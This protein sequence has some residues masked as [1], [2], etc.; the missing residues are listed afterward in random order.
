MSLGWCGGRAQVAA[1]LAALDDDDWSVRQAAWVAL[2]NLT[3]MEWPFD[4]LASRELQAR[5]A[6]K[7]RDWWAATPTDRPPPEALKLLKEIHPRPHN[8]AQGAKVTASSVYKGPLEALTDGALQGAFWQTKKVPF[9]QWVVVDLGAVRSIGSVVVHQYGPGFCLTDYELQVSVDGK[10]FEQVLRKKGRTLPRLNLRFDARP[11]RFVRLVSYA[12]ENKTYPTTLRE[13]EAYAETPA[14]NVASETVDHRLERGLRAMGALGGSGSVEAALR[15]LEPH[16]DREPDSPAESTMVQAGLRSL[17]R[18]GD[19]RALEALVEFLDQPYWARFA[20]DAL[21]DLGDERAAPALLAAYPHYARDLDDKQPARIPADDRPGF[22]AADRMYETPFEIAS[23]LARLPLERPEILAALRRIGP[24]LAVNIPSNYDGAMIYEPEAFQAITAHLLGSAGLRRASCEAAFAALGLPVEPTGVSE[25]DVLLKLAQRRHGEIPHAAAWLPT[26]CEARDVKPLIALLR[27]ENGWVRINAAKALMFLGAE[28]AVEP[29]MSILA[30]SKTEAEY[31]WFGGFVFGTPLQGH[32]EYNA[33]PPRWR[34][35]FVRALGRLRATAS[36]PLLEKTLNDDRNA[37]EVR[38]AAAMALDEIGGP[39]ALTELRRAE[40]GHPFHSVRL[41]AREALWRRGLLMDGDP[42]DE[43]ST[44][45]PISPAVARPATAA[46]DLRTGSSAPD[47]IVFIKGPNRMP[48]RFQI[49]PWRQTYS[50][51]DS[52][53]TY[54][55][56]WNLYRLEPPEPQGRLTQLTRFEDGYVADCEVSWDGRRIVFA[57]RGGE[58]DPWWHIWEIN[59]D[60][61]GLRQLTRGPYHDV[62]PVQLGD[63]RI[64]FSSSRIG[65]RDEYHGYHATGLTVMNADGGDIHCIGFNLGRDDEPAVLPDGRIV[66]SRLELFYS[67]LKTERTLHAVFPDGTQDVTLYGP[68]RRGFWREITRKSGEK[69]WGEAPPRHRVLRLTQPQPFE[70]NRVLCATTGGLTL[71]GPGSLQEELVPH[72]QSLAATSPFPLGNGEILCAA[73]TKK[74]SD[75]EGNLALYRLDAASG[76]MRLVYRDPEAA[77]F[78]ARPLVARRPP[79]VLPESAAS[80][81]HGYTAELFCASVNNSRID[82]VARRAKL[83]RVIEGMPAVSRHYTHLSH[84]GPAWKNHA[85]TLARVL[86]TVPLAADGSFLVEVPADRLLHVQALDSDR[87]VVGNQ[88][89]WMYGRP[90]ERR[91][92]VGCHEP[93]DT[94]PALTAGASALAATVPPLLALPTGGELTYRAKAWQKGVLADE[95]EEQTRTVRA[96]SLLGRK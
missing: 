47:A 77:S 58:N 37:L 87:R 80:R 17:G 42:V 79:A 26:L 7:W 81:S 56:G 34:E 33:P 65:A 10:R 61:S 9:P 93:R 18:S 4:A 89:I 75:E 49:D 43:H 94:A 76:A 41:V 35:A 78:E 46:A 29:V 5:Q 95:T 16:A 45:V 19:P 59:A 31:G 57:R 3:G 68:E 53:P 28:E 83:A 21:G 73:V 66:F 13:I 22:E 91:S 36:V 74:L 51:T 60:G 32:D 40:A 70:G 67:R 52:G 54:R 96:V 69:W 62:Q 12:A 8:L 86:G 44:A 85:G 11:A 48:N 30:G 39:T 38:Y 50:T 71:A 15:I 6:Q 88:Q 63:G 64:V 82:R 20:A 27:H 23:A 55:L 92:C 1:L 2:T 90:G 84:D 72:D 14:A 24:L 25:W